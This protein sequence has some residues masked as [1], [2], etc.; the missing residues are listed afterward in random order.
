[1]KRN[2]KVQ[3]TKQELQIQDLDVRQHPV[4]ATDLP[5]DFKRT[6]YTWNDKYGITTVPLLVKAKSGEL[7]DDKRLKGIFIDGNYRKI[8]SRLYVVYPNEE[9]DAFLKDNA[10]RL[11]LEIR[12]TY[13]SHYGDAKYWELL[14]STME[15]NIE[16]KKKN[17]VLRVGVMVR[18]SLGTYVSLGADLFTWRVV[19]ENGMVTRGHD[20]G[21]AL[22][23]VGKNPQKLFD[24]FQ[25]GIE[26]VLNKTKVLIEYYKK[27][28]N[29][30]MNKA[31]AEALAKRLPV[32]KFPSCMTY[33]YKKH[34]TVLLRNDDMWKAFNDVTERL[35]HPERFHQKEIG[36]LTTSAAE[37]HLQMV[38]EKAVDG[39]YA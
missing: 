28:A 21:F 30:R 5:F 23:H 39:R 25:Q 17:D 4:K 15:E 27:A 11:N 35:W 29:V 13:E 18:N 7:Y 9:V 31:I 6:D 32:K 38:L 33:D 37:R 10:K 8:V 1:M 34:E 12:N 19:C 22:R 26:S 16:Y 20:M 24:A 3:A 14:H 36:F 2:L